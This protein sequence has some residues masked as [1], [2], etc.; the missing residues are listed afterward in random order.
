[1]LSASI[2]ALYVLDGPLS[3]F[4]YKMIKWCC[5]PVFEERSR[6]YA[7]LHNSPFATKVLIYPDAGVSSADCSQLTAESLPRHH[8]HPKGAFLPRGVSPSLRQICIHNLS[9]ATTI[10]LACIISGLYY[11]PHCYQGGQFY[12]TIDYHHFCPTEKT[13]SQ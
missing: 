13:A 3:Y 1:M 10:Y 8:P 4:I 7:V 9:K 11:H 12:I 6:C 2:Y 5:P